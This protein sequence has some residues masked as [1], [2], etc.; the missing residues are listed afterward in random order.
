[1]YQSIS[2]E[3]EGVSNHNVFTALVF[4]EQLKIQSRIMTG[5]GHT[6]TGR[7]AVLPLLRLTAAPGQTENCNRI[8]YRRSS[9]E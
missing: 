1:M 9:T 2:V 4:M 3:M 6:H 7:S 8:R 5:L